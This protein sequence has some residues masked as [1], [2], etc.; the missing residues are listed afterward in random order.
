MITR[1]KAL[2][3]RVYRTSGSTSSTA[4]FESRRANASANKLPART[5]CQ[6]FAAILAPTDS[7]RTTSASAM[8]TD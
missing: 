6:T 4:A 7:R 1:A 8:R 5:T 2:H 3:A